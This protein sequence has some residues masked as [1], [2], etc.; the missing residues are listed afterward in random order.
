MIRI[1]IVEDEPRVRRCL[2]QR[3]ELEAD[4]DVVAEA[5]D[6]PSAL[7]AFTTDPVDVVLMDARLPG[8]DGL[9]VAAVLRCSDPAP[10]VVIHALHDSAAVRARAAELGAAFV[11]KGEPDEPLLVAIRTGAIG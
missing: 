7:A 9:E 8:M 1:L 11:A 2:R 10:R 4:L 5:V 6:G 3:L